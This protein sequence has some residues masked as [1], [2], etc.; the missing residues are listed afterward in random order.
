MKEKAIDLII[1]ARKN[2]AKKK[3]KNVRKFVVPR[4]HNFNL[5]AE[6]FIDL[7]RWETLE[8]KI[9]TAPAIIAEYSDEELVNLTKENLPQFLCHS[10]AR[11]FL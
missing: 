9:F 1:K 4:P 5:E 8:S 6:D 10:Q 3:S 11:V 2:Q 7:I